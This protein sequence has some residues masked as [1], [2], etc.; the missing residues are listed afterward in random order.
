MSFQQAQASSQLDLECWAL[1]HPREG[2][3]KVLQACAIAKGQG[4]GYL[5][6][7]TCCIDKTSLTELSEA[8]NYMFRWYAETEVCYAYLAD[9]PDDDHVN[10]QHSSFRASRWFT[11]GWTLQE[12]IAPKEVL[13]YSSG[14]KLLGSRTDLK[15]L[16][17]SI[18]GIPVD[19]LTT[20]EPRPPARSIGEIFS[21]AS[22]RTTTLE[23]D[24][25]YSLLGLLN[26]NLPLIYG[27]GTAAFMRVQEE[28]LRRYDDESIFAWEAPPNEAITKPVSGLLSPSVTYFRASHR[29]VKPTIRTRLDQAPVM[30]TNKGIVVDLLLVPDDED[31]GNHLALLN[32][33]IAGTD[34][35]EIQPAIRVQH[36]GGRQ[37]ARV[38]LHHIHDI[39]I[40]AHIFEAKL[41]AS[42]SMIFPHDPQI[43]LPVTAFVFD[44]A[45][46]LLI[47]VPDSAYAGY[48]TPNDESIRLS[49]KVVQTSPESGWETSW[50]R[51]LID[52]TRQPVRTPERIGQL[53]ALVGHTTSPSLIGGLKTEFYQGSKCIGSGYILCGL[54]RLENKSLGLPERVLPWCCILPDP[55]GAVPNDSPL[56]TLPQQ[57]R[58]GWPT[59]LRLPVNMQLFRDAAH[60]VVAIDVAEIQGPGRVVYEISLARSHF[61]TG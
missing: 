14:W 12:L 11:R 23:E 53:G 29:F 28:L 26:I 27:E 46:T 18:T 31:R 41:P 49:L 22:R 6:A 21:W 40:S 36:L 4:Y 45:Q 17:S 16:V 33:R 54:D 61:T 8:I 32:C 42:W 15:D 58:S 50:S 52:S 51:L 19:V 39:R 1:R 9:V 44:P 24:M 60:I 5:W 48:T 34:E 56:H 59:E 30:I 37:Y 20:G 57:P 3:Q 13:F 25:A 2:W 10:H 38:D 7:D 55:G 47:P 43:P 35:S